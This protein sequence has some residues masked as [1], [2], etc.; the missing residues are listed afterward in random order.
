M[1]IYVYKCETCDGI[2]EALQRFS[3][4]PLTVCPSCGG[5]LQK[6][7]SPEFGLSFKGSGFYI[8]DYKNRSDGKN[9]KAEKST[10]EKKEQKKSTPAETTAS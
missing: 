2:H 7:F 4:P 9:G 8:T 5:A 6:Q 3:D 1:P 10:P